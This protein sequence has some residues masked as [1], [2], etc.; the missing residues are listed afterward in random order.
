MVS[1]LHTVATKM[2]AQY[3]QFFLFLSDITLSYFK[4]AGRKLSAITL[5]GSEI[6]QVDALKVYEKIKTKPR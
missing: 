1:D 2:S 6:V 4:L 3:N 5:P